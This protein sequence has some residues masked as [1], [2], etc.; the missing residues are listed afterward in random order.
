M[1]ENQPKYTKINPSKSQ[2]QKDQNF[3]KR[4]KKF[5]KS[6]TIKDEIPD[7]LYN[8][9]SMVR[10]SE[11]LSN[12]RKNK[13]HM[14]QLENNID[15]PDTLLGFNEYKEIKTFKDTHYARKLRAS[16]LNPD[17]P[18]VLEPINEIYTSNMPKPYIIKEESKNQ[19]ITENNE[20]NKED[21]NN[22]DKKEEE[23][24][25]EVNSEEEKKVEE[26]IEEENNLKAKKEELEKEKLEK[27]KRLEEERL[28]IEE[29][30]K[31]LEENKRLDEE[32]SKPKGN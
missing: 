27:L 2:L 4:Q 16:S 8:S 32:D 10:Q 1:L 17:L 25:I 18:D 23:I 11:K 9:N 13:K 3:I 22:D 30:K 21:F 7:A 20:N 28:K 6:K 14:S 19:E 31:I 15:L 5:Y 12:V 29:E 26:K 24:K